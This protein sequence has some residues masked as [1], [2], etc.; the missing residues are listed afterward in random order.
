[1]KYR[2]GLDIGVA[3]VGWAVLQNDNKGSPCRILGR[4]VRV[5]EAAETPKDGKSLAEGRREAR[6]IRRSLRRKKHRSDRI[7]K[8]IVDNFSMLK[9]ELEALFKDTKSQACIYKIRYEALTRKLSKEE[10]ARLLVHLSKKRG[11]KSNRKNAKADSS[12]DGK[13]L[14]ATNKTKAL[15]LENDYKT[16][17]EYLYKEIVEKN[18][19]ILHQNKELKNDKSKQGKI[20]QLLRTRNTTGDYSLTFLREL[21]E[22]EVDIIFDSQRSFGN[23]LASRDME[24]KYK[25]ILLFQRPFDMGPGFGSMWGWG[26]GSMIERMIG[27]CT[28]EN[29]ANGFAI[30][31]TRA[32]IAS[33]T[34]ERFV[35]LSKINNLRLIQGFKSN[36][37]SQEQ[38]DIIFKLA[39]KNSKVTFSQIRKALALADCPKDGEK[40]EFTFNL[41]KYISKKKKPKDA[42]AVQDVD[43]EKSIYIDSEKSTFYELKAY[44][45]ITKALDSQVKILDGGQLCDTTWQLYDDIAY[46][47]TFY[48]NEESIEKALNKLTMSDTI[49]EKLL[50]SNLHFSGVGNLSIKA[51]KNILPFLAQGETYDKSAELAGYDF[52]NQNRGGTRKNKLR[53]D[54][55]L[56]T[57]S[58]NSP[59]VK[60]AISQTFK[61]V[62]AIIRQYGKPEVILIELARDMAKNFSE[63]KDIEKSQEENREKNERAIKEIQS[64]GVSSPK[65]VDI[66]KLRLWKEQQNMCAYSQ[67]Q[68]PI[69][70]L[71]SSDN[72]VQVDH[73]IPYSMCFDNSRANKVLVY[74]HENQ[75]KGNR[76]AY[77]YIA[78][79]GEQSLKEYEIW[80]K[81]YVWSKAKKAKLLARE[82]D[83]REMSDRNLTDTKHATK[84]I[85]NYIRNNLQFNSDEHSKFTNDRVIQVNGAI[86]SYIRKR[87]FFGD[88]MCKNRDTDNHHAQDACYIAIADR[89][90]TQRI[91]NFEK[92]NKERHYDKANKN[93]IHKVTGQVVDSK[94]QL[95]D[96][97][98]TESMDFGQG[99]PP[100]YSNFKREMQMWFDLNP[101]A[102]TYLQERHQDFIYYGQKADDTPEKIPPLFVSRMSNH[103]ITGQAHQ[104]TIK[105]GITVKTQAKKGNVVIENYTIKKISLDS[106][107]LDGNGE[108]LNY[109]NPSSDKLLYNALKERLAAHGGDAKKAFTVDGKGKEAIKFFKPRLLANGTVVDGPEVKKVKLQETTSLNVFLD[110]VGGIAQNGSM[111][112]IDVFSISKG[113]DLLGTKG[114]KFYFVPIYVADFKKQELPNLSAPNGIAMNESVGY[115][116]EFSLYA[117]DLILVKSKSGIKAE[118]VGKSAD[119]KEIKNYKTIAQEKPELLYYTG[120]DISSAR[121]SADANNREFKGIRVGIQNLE[122]FEKWEVDVLGNYKKAPF[123]PRDT[124]TLYKGRKKDHLKINNYE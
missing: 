2:I 55:L 105:R 91:S 9:E 74:S 53:L 94:S 31:E 99:F 120:A 40:P 28:F 67:K 102:E 4:G 14:E 6:S 43:T 26:E 117:K 38:K 118:I 89:A 45:A 34:Y 92:R 78:S 25:A 69:Q 11:F 98:Q 24:E 36:S 85:A 49:K 48:K 59:V 5:F 61:V 101:N 30:D 82:V 50:N 46:T 19:Y 21:I 33:Y 107:K 83:E 95:Y 106:L 81:T 1:M 86:T 41:C 23:E 27:I 35:L 110:K 47:F 70:I 10:F 51:I 84:T 57:E 22:K 76:L 39:H 12:D 90:M 7:R 97:Q 62:N 112:R 88:N 3:S 73:I 8:L 96:L 121:V 32:P 115:K 122:V 18:E 16:V 124:R 58:I 103:K 100:P 71:F 123:V 37:L 65:G 15:I 54:D 44:N 68:I 63:R 56:K 109:Y 119:G 29:K 113:D 111:V 79:K 87:L 17:G 116:F 77:N 13:L 80:V 64:Y 108:I 72:A 114:K 60:R 75:N 52:R 66:E 42:S 104:E 20:Q 93:F